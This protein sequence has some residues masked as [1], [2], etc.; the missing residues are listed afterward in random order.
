[1]AAIAVRPRRPSS[2][3]VE[4][5]L[6]RP[7]TARQLH[8]LE[9]AGLI[10]A[11][12]AMTDRRGTVFAIDPRNHGRITAWLAGTDIGRR[13]TAPFYDDPPLGDD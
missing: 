11:T 2:L 5:G 3:A 1:M 9:D 13:L 10:R 7:A 8:L 6:S 4:V 12:R